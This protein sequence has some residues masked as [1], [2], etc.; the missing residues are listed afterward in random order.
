MSP[1]R[2]L[3]IAVL[4]AVASP[5]ATAQPTVQGQR[6]DACSRGNV[7]VCLKLLRRPRLEAGRRAAIEFHLAELETLLVACS[8]G[9]ATACGTV[10]EKYPDLPADLWYGKQPPQLKLE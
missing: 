3:L 10:T 6:L 7:Q 8:S 5:P 2:Q 4:V 9:D 1:V